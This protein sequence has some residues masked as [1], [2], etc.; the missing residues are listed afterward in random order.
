MRCD[1]SFVKLSQILG[2][3]MHVCI[4]VRPSCLQGS[5]FLG[6][7]SP[8]L[9]RGLDSCCMLVV[10]TQAL[11]TLGKRVEGKR[12]VPISTPASFQS[13]LG[14][15]VPAPTDVW[16]CLPFQVLLGVAR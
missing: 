3:W 16:L 8:T 7:D 1:V 13:S 6:L 11:S 15:S 5:S 4:R 10:D 14:V 2:S 9:V 12:V